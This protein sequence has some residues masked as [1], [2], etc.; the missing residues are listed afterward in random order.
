M[1]TRD[2]VI[3]LQGVR[4]RL[5]SGWS[6][7]QGHP[8]ELDLRAKEAAAEAERERV[9]AAWNWGVAD[10]DALPV[11][12]WDSGPAKPN[13]AQLRVFDALGD[14]EGCLPSFDEFR[15]W[16]HVDG[17]TLKTALTALSERFRMI[18]YRQIPRGGGRPH[19]WRVVVNGRE[20]KSARWDEVAGG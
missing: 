4:L 6:G 15:L 20:L 14:W 12:I 11:E 1:A 3:A 10:P 5:P 13:K 9:R 18:E 17:K 19:V 7:G 2:E 8:R 16:A